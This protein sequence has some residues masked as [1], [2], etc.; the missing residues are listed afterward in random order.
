LTCLICADVASLSAQQPPSGS[1]P[2]TTD[3]EEPAAD[4][5]PADQSGALSTAEG[6]AAHTAAATDAPVAERRRAWSILYYHSE[7]TDNSVWEVLENRGVVFRY[8]SLDS[9]DLEYELD[10]KNPLRKLFRPLLSTIQVGAVATKQHDPHSS[11]FEMAA[12][13]M[14]RW[15]KLPL[16]K[17]VLMSIGVG[18]GIS[19]ASSIPARELQGA[20][21]HLLDFMALEATFALPSRPQLE[22]VPRIHHRSSA[23]GF[24]GDSIS[25]NALSLGVRYSF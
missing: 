20:G 16:K 11:G 24:F 19:Y 12:Y 17:Y 25:S 1:D 8:G 2:W 22:I 3:A 4:P 6:E 15:R 23:W 5:P 9:L 10:E 14:F 13:L 18:E 7:M 21:K